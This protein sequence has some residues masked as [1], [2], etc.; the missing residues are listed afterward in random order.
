ME[1]IA[2]VDEVGRG[3]LAGPVV[4]AAVILPDN[5]T[6]VGLR[7]SKKLSK[8]KREKLFPIIQ[9]QALGIGIGEVDVKTIDKIN[10]REATFKAMQIALGKLPIRPTKALIDGHPLK[11]QII[12]NEGIIG[13]D[14]LVDSIKAASII[15]KVTRDNMMDE[16]GNIFPEYGFEKHK[17]YGTEFHMNALKQYRSTPIHRRS[18][19]PVNKH[20]P[21]FNWLSEQKRIGWMGEKLAALYLKS[22]G[23]T[24]LEM[25]RSC[26]PYGEIDIIAKNKN[27]LVFVEVKTAY[28]S[29]PDSLD[30]KVDNIKLTKMGHAIQ[31][32]QNQVEQIEDFRIDCIS[33]IL[34]KNKPFFK[35]FEGILLD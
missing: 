2:G 18:F 34:Q 12:P 16:Y 10:I 19:N 21:T 33:V 4:A 31:H 15:A 25:N 28:K 17:G 22:K 24:I 26:L 27:E 35:H 32:Y 30:E 29:N 6:I 1:I 23:L 5:H 7:D 8:I 13:G 11:S 3:P 9:D 14:D 20:M